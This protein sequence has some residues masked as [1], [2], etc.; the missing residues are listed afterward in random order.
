M[1]ELIV[2]A[3]ILVMLLIP[4]LAALMGRMNDESRKPGQQ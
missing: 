4:A 2:L 3:G 1:K